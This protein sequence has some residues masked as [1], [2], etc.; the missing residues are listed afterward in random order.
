[1]SE[2]GILVPEVGELE[3]FYPLS[4]NHGIE[5]ANEVLHCDIEKDNNLTN[6]REFAK[7]IHVAVP[8]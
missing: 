4:S 2:L 3:S 8:R 6:A 7:K 1:M 5:W